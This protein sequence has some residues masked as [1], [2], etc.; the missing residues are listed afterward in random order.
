MK[1]DPND[2]EIRIPTTQAEKQALVRMLSQVWSFEHNLYE[3]TLYGTGPGIYN[4]TPYTLFRG[5][6]AVGNLSLVEMRVFWNGEPLEVLGFASVA[7]PETYRGNGIAGRLMDHA[8]GIIDARG[9]PS[10]LFTGLPQVYASRGFRIVGL[11]A[12]ALPEE[13]PASERG[14]SCETLATYDETSLAAVRTLY[15]EILPDFDGKLVRDPAYWTVHR[16]AFDRTR[17]ASLTLCQIGRA[18]V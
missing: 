3:E 6:E 18:H 9:V 5:S 1:L 14:V 16:R 17:E 10:V 4:W 15:E 13:L 7:T 11:H 12:V 8:L 2:L